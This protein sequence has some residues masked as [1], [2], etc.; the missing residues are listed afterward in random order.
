M[1]VT[2]QEIKKMM[3]EMLDDFEKETE[4]IF[5]NQ[6]KAVIAI[7][8]S[9]TKILNERLDKLETNIIANASKIK[10]IEKEL[11]EIKESL[12]FNEHVIGKKIENNNKH[13]FNKIDYKQLEKERFNNEFLNEKIRNLEDRSQRGNLRIDGICED[14]VESWEATEEKVHLFFLQKL[15][16]KG[17]EI[18]RAHRTGPKKVGRPRVIV[19]KLQQY[20]DKAKIFK[21]SNRL[22]GTN[23]YVNE[24]FSRETVAIRRKLFAEVKERPLNGESVSVR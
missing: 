1:A 6:E 4:V 19:L 16:L 18:E 24:D 7:V 23:I 21:E 8:S 13:L 22:R 15:G 3:K 14:E 2:F 10:K 5:K 17:I 20:K 11:E 12:N 9:N